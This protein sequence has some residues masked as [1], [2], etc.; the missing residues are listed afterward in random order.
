MMASTPMTISNLQPETLVQLQVTN[1]IRLDLQTTATSKHS[2]FNRLPR[3][4]NT[5]PIINLNDHPARIKSKLT[6]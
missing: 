4:W 6:E 1:S 2:Y 5:L 3:I